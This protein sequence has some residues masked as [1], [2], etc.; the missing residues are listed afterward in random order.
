MRLNCHPLVFITMPLQSIPH[1]TAGAPRPYRSEL[2]QQQAEQTRSRVL[3]AAVELF[4]EHGYARTTLAKIADAAGVSQETVQLQGAK[5]ALM[6]AA[7]ER[8]AFGV[9]GESNVLEME[10]GRQFLA[11][12]D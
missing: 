6:V 11:I 2:R 8:A 1:R 9:T 3:A 5:A 4:A 12:E 7:I 10:V